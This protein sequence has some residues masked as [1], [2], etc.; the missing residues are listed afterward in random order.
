MK[1]K[2]AVKYQTTGPLS[3]Y[4][5][6]TLPKGFLPGSRLVYNESAKDKLNLA[7]QNLQNTVLSMP[8]WMEFNNMLPES[9]L[10]GSVLNPQLGQQM[11]K[12]ASQDL[13]LGRASSTSTSPSL[14]YNPV[15]SLNYAASPSDP[16]HIGPSGTEY[17]IT[18]GG[19]EFDPSLYTNYTHDPSFDLSQ[20]YDPEAYNWLNSPSE[21]I[22]SE[23]FTETIPKDVS[24]MIQSGENITKIANQYGISP[25]ELYAANQYSGS[26]Y[27]LKNINQIRSGRSLDIPGQFETTS[28]VRDVVTQGPSN[29][30][31]LDRGPVSPGGTPSPENINP[32][33]T[34]NYL[35]RTGLHGAMA[36]LAGS[37]ISKASDDQDPTTL[38]GGETIG[39]LIGSGGTG[40]SIAAGL[41]SMSPKLA[42]IPGLGWIGAGLGAGL[43][44]WGALRRRRDARR[45]KKKAIK[46]FSKRVGSAG[47]GQRKAEIQAKT[48]SGRDTGRRFTRKLGGGVPYNL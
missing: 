1:N 41:G 5:M 24:H 7:S 6:N 32:M 10:S 28:G 3:H 17:P 29:I 40:A 34:A 19:A 46:K 15:Q 30:D 11:F 37:L 42:A 26:G 27:H 16:I 33:N 36:G 44:I 47:L 2:K 20:T 43:G 13:N 12:L 25:Q 31:L 35:K 38:T 22:T 18:G 9:N 48:V 23:A 14:G 45:E 8:D 4:G 21:T 39:Q